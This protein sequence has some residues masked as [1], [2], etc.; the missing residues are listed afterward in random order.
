MLCFISAIL[1][2]S[3]ILELIVS[4]T[5]FAL[6]TRFVRDAKLMKDDTTAVVR[7]VPLNRVLCFPQMCMKSVTSGHLSDSC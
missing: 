4:H 2:S 5:L 6:L 3:H 1:A 7:P